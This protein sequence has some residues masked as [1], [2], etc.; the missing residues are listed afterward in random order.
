MKLGNQEPSLTSQELALLKEIW[1]V[2]QLRPSGHQR[3]TGYYL[4]H[5]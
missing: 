2:I 5:F 3:Q 4:R 1:N